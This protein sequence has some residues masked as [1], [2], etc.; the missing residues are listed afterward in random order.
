MSRAGGQ[1][2]IAST[3]R[4]RRWAASGGLEYGIVEWAIIMAA[5]HT[6]SHTQAICLSMVFH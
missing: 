5:R 6:R 3:G 2:E 1:V 4:D